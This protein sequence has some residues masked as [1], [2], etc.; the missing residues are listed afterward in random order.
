[1]LKNSSGKVLTVFL[2][3]IA[4]LL[5]SLTAVSLFFFQRE[6]EKRKETEFTLEKTKAS[7]ARLEEELKE[8]KK[9][10]ILLEEKNK[11][12]DEQINSL[13]DD[14]EVE[15]GLKEEVK[16]ENSSLKEQLD[17]A[18][19]ER[20]SLQQQI[21]DNSAGFEEKMAA[22]KQEL[23]TESNV[24]QQ[25]EAANK[26]LQEKV[27]T[28]EKQIEE[29]SQGADLPE[30]TPSDI[31]KKPNDGSPQSMNV[32]LDKIVV[33]PSHGLEGRVI[34]VDTASEFVIFNLGEKDGITADKTFSI[35]RG[36]N[37]LGDVKVT[38]VQPEMS[39]ADLIPPLSAKMIR[40]NDR[41]LVKQ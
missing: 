32:E 25:L 16:K 27:T 33:V 41:V 8:T 14:L 23:E 10:N 28:L 31:K 4:V 15:K 36:T 6:T 22:L 40:K 39:A 21:A 11:E 35:Y 9:Q 26:E 34:N 24:K 3:I 20:D 13:L 12:V 29:R 2:V 17:A 18:L 37:Y 38:S 30:N 1:M 7:H 19:K 5:I